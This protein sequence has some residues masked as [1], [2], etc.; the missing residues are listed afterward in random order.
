MATTQRQAATVDELRQVVQELLVSLRPGMLIGLSGS[1]GVGKTTF[2]KILAELMGVTEDVISPTYI[3]HQSYTL[4]N[5]I[6]GIYRL[7]HLDLYRVHS[8]QDFDTLDL[9]VN[10]PAGLVCVEWIDQVP[11]LAKQAD[12]VIVLTVRDEVRTLQFSWRNQ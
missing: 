3:Y 6:Q 11:K 5:P 2:V 8:D 9:T 10:D 1:L 4:L 12:L 7:H